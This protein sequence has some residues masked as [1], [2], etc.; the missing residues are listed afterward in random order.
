MD[1]KITKH[2]NK[3][4]AAYKKLSLPIKTYTNWKW[5]NGKWYSKQME[6]NWWK[7]AGVLISDKIR[8]WNKNYEKRQIGSLYKMIKG[9]SNKKI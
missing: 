1:K 8:L 9:S 2:K 5:K 4:Y 3:Q 7:Q 6:A